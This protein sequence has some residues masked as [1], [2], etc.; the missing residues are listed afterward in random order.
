MSVHQSNRAGAGRGP[1]ATGAG[2]LLDDDSDRLEPI[3]LLLVDDRPS[4]LE[5]LALILDDPT[6]ELVTAHSGAEALKRVLADDFALIIMDVMLPA[7]DGF[8]VAAMVKTRDRSKHTPI[9]FLTAAGSDM[10]F[11]YRAYAVGAV[12]YLSKPIDPDV[13][14]AKVAIFADLY[15]KDLRIQRQAEALR[16][17]DRRRQEL[18]LADLRRSTAER[19]RNLADAIPAIVWTA[20]PDGALSHANRGWH[21][22]TGFGTERTR[23]WGWLEA[24]HSD[25]VNRFEEGWRAAIAAECE[26]KAECRIRRAEGGYRWHLCHAVPEHDSDTQ[27]VIGWIATMTDTEDL[28]RAIQARDEFLAVASHE[29]RTPL[30]TLDLVIHGLRRGIEGE[31]PADQARILAKLATGER[32]IR[33]LD[34]LVSALLDVTRIAG[35]RA[36]VELVDCDMAEIA[37]EVVERL[38]EEATRLGGELRLSAPKTVPGR[39]DPLRMDQVLTNLVT[40]AIRHGSGKPIDVMVEPRDESICLV[41][42]DHGEGIPAE[43]L[44]RLFGRFQRGASRTREGGLGLGLFISRHIVRAHGGDV[45]VVSEPGQGATFTVELPLHI[46]GDEQGADSGS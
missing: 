12:D 20:G 24:I 7:M 4:D 40:N 44:P 18:E 37:K 34:R 19:Y 2:H 29:L 3:K 1:T 11:I 17:A 14:K 42:K 46:P 6:Y 13:L 38:Q 27:A 36:M 16:A 10:R 45:S 23:G 28:R 8:E 31:Q 5:T 30:S 32:Q 21:E 15:R 39:W 35:R 25:D 22:I 26:Y 43:Q 9:L 33:R 41:V